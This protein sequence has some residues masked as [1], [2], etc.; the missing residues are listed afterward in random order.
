MHEKFQV[1][2]LQ[3][4]AFLA[5]TVSYILN[6]LKKI[7]ENQMPPKLHEPFARNPLTT[8]LACSALPLN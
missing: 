2:A 5:V 7:R 3:S 8:F 1:W 6:F 4:K